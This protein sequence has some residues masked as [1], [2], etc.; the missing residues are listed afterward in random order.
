MI[1]SLSEEQHTK[2]SSVINLRKSN[3][4]CLY[5]NCKTAEV[6]LPRA[7][8]TISIYRSVIL[9]DILK[10]TVNTK[11]KLLSLD[12]AIY[13][14]LSKMEKE[15]NAA[16]RKAGRSP[17]QFSSKHIEK[18][19]G[20]WRKTKDCLCLMERNKTCTTQK[21]KSTLSYRHITEL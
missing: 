12:I 5:I 18:W 7:S 15:I 16:L 6:P 9:K 4:H 10:W 3:M 2:I 14:A 13:S 17:M 11:D 21:S 20:S 1:E 19:P 8:P